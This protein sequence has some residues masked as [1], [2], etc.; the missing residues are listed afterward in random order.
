MSSSS[1]QRAAMSDPRL[2]AVR[3]QI[4][5]R[6]S[7][8]STGRSTTSPSIGS[9]TSSRKRSAWARRSACRGRRYRGWA[10]SPSSGT[11]RPT[12]LLSGRW[13]APP[14]EGSRCASGTR[15]QSPESNQVPSRI[16][17]TPSSGDAGR[18]VK[19][20]AAGP[21]C[22]D[23]FPDDRRQGGAMSGKSGGRPAWIRRTRSVMSNTGRPV[24]AWMSAR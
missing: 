6:R 17:R 14:P 22:G 2:A 7:P 16:R 10:G 9:T 8:E 18:T 4:V 24:T 15:H 13:T 20:R 21:Q 12:S 5:V 11:P 19:E 1:G 3:R 23:L